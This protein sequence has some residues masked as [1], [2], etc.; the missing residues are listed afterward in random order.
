VR[1][2]SRNRLHGGLWELARRLASSGELASGGLPCWQIA[3]CVAGRAAS[4]LAAR[5]ARA[6]LAGHNPNTTHSI[7]SRTHSPRAATHHSATTTNPQCGVRGVERGTWWCPGGLLHTTH[8]T[9]TPHYSPPAALHIK[10]F[11][12]PW[13]KTATPAGRGPGFF[14]FSYW[15]LAINSVS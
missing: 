7:T 4:P 10:F 12:L 3:D 9:H 15:L 5:C 14:S 13:R 11:V 6:V 1:G 2:A 8:T